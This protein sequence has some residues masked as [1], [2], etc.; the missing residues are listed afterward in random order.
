MC[1]ETLS[2]PVDL[3][4]WCKA[5][6]FSSGNTDGNI[7]NGQVEIIAIA[8]TKAFYIYATFIW[9]VGR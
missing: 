8:Q 2:D 7:A 1:L 9:P 6:L 5:D 4:K 3:M